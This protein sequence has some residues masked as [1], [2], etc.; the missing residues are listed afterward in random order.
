MR[1]RRQSSSGFGRLGP[2]AAEMFPGAA[3][4]R[5]AIWKP[6]LVS[7]VAEC[8]LLRRKRTAELANRIPSLLGSSP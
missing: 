5:S 7:L 6:T 3:R 4:G 1:R 8:A 2:A